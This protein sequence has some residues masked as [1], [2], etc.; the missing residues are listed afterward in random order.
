MPGVL[1]VLFVVVD[2]AK[3]QVFAS[4]EFVS[5]KDPRQYYIFSKYSVFKLQKLG[6]RVSN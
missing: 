1:R 5:G 6:N 4:Q 2:N 3:S